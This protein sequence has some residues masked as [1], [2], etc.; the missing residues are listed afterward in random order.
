MRI[1]IL[2]Q[3]G[4]GG[5]I[6]FAYMLARAMAESGVKVTLVTASDYELRDLPH[7][8]DVMLEFVLWP[9]MES[10]EPD[11]SA[12]AL[13]WVGRFHRRVIRRGW[14]ALR[15]SVEMWRVA[16]AVGRLRPDVVQVRPF[17]LAGHGMILKRLKKSGATIVEICHEF[18]PRDTMH[19][20]AARLEKRLS[21]ADSHMIDARLFLGGRI[22]SRYAS[23]HPGFPESRMFVIPH[24]DGELFQ[25]LADSGSDLGRQYGIA[26]DDKVVLFFGNLRPSKGLEDLLEGFARA[27]RPPGSKLLVAGYPGLDVEPSSLLELATKLSIDDSVV[28]D[29]SYIPNQDV[30]PLIQLCRFLV[31]PYRNAT[32]SGPLHIALTFGKPVLATNTGGIGDVI[33]DRTTGLLVEPG[34][35]DAIANGIE[36]LLWDDEMVSAMTAA[37]QD[38]MVAYRWSAVAAGVLG[39]VDSVR[40]KTSDQT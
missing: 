35:I 40:P 17:P 24:G 31:L 38:R 27:R 12:G 6:H 34:D 10:R 19:P 23:L 8:F 22:R 25:L 14:R 39:A 4:T 2:E 32:Q 15:L 18:E 20:I 9:R 5:M 36:R 29:M 33:E 1:V 37:I 30:G 13:S 11:T 7:D 16:G 26:P 28:F 3:D 21:G